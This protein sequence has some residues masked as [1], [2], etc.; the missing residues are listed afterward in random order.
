MLTRIELDGFKS[1]EDFSLDLPPHA[2]VLGTNAAGKSNLFDAIRFL[3]A[4]ASGSVAEA[5]ERMRGLPHELFSFDAAG[6]PREE[7]TLAA[8]VLLPRRIKDPWGKSIEVRFP[9]IRY[10]V[11]LQRRQEGVEKVVV[12]EEEATAIYA[13]DDNWRPYGKPPSTGFRRLFL[14]ARPGPDNPKGRTRRDAPFLA[15]VD[16]RFEIHHD[17]KAG[18]MRELP[19][20]GSDATLLS[21]MGTADEFA[22]LYALREELRS[23][24]FFQID[25]VAIR[26]PSRTSWATALEPDGRNLGRVLHRLRQETRSEANPDGV[27]P[28]ITADL[29]RLIGGIKHVHVDPDEQTRDFRIRLEMADGLPYS[30]HLASDG[31]LRL[32][33]LLTAMSDR[34]SAGLL[35]M[36]EPENGVHPARL[37]LLVEQLRS[38]VPD[39]HS[40]EIDETQ[41]LHQVLTNSHSPV[42][43]SAIRDH[44]GEALL[45]DVVTR[46][47][48][49]GPVRRTR[50]RPV[51][52]SNQSSL[53]GNNADEVG[54]AEVERYLGSVIGGA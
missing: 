20:T 16:E 43:L 52:A 3:S 4:L 14:Q 49:A 6:K 50:I 18:R 33:A 19:A 29:R 51:N 23:W 42:I 22:H 1:F 17:G 12:L 36:E 41:P 10:K 9:R 15:T 24:R 53:L 34:A 44:D 40:A 5:A 48:A 54:K 31:T 47:T 26:D 45:A 38:F 37:R 11:K 32:L 30:A 27:L 25:P 28:E 7:M 2:V 8:E 46:T 21:T 13:S 35:C 39:P